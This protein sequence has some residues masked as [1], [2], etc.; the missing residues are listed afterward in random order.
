MV[1]RAVSLNFTSSQE[2][3]IIQ[4]IGVKVT[5]NQMEEKK[6]NFEKPL[7]SARHFTSGASPENGS[8]WKI[9][10]SV[11][12]VRCPPKYKSELKS[13]PVSNPGTVPFE[14]EQIPGRPKDDETSLGSHVAESYK[15]PNLPPGRTLRVG[16]QDFDMA[17]PVVH[18]DQTRSVSQ[19][20]SNIQSLDENVTQSG[21]FRDVKEEVGNSSSGNEDEEFV[22][23]LETLSR[24]ES[25]LINCSLSGLSGL[26]DSGM[27]ECG[28]SPIDSQT[29]D[30][31]MGRFLPAA[32]A[33]A[34]DAPQHASRK[35][36]V[37]RQQ[38]RPPSKIV[39]EDKCPQLRYGPDF[40]LEY[41][42]RNGSEYEE[43]DTDYDE[44]EKFQGKL[45]GLLP[46][47]G[48]RNSLCLLNPLPGMSMRSRTHI[49]PLKK[50]QAGTSSWSCSGTDR[51]ISTVGLETS[52]HQANSKALENY[53]I[54]I[55]HISLDKVGFPSFRE[56]MA[57]ENQSK[58]KNIGSPVAEKTLYVDTEDEVRSLHVRSCSS[59][60]NVQ[61]EF[62]VKEQEI[63][64]EERDQSQNLDSSL[65]NTEALNLM[66][67]GVQSEIRFQIHDF[68]I[69]SS[70]SEAN[71]KTRTGMQ[72]PSGQE[73]DI[74]KGSKMLPKG[75]RKSESKIY[76]ELLAPPPLPKSPS[77][78]W[79]GRTLTSISRK[80]TSVHSY[81]GTWIT[82][83]DQASN[84]KSS[85]PKWETLVRM[86]KMQNKHLGFSEDLLTPIPEA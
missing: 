1:S 3:S 64:D 69:V 25:L 12:S 13:G 49:P 35:Q 8:K 17:F 41:S 53:D 20:S 65:I 19:D 55:H 67:K 40:A 32:K 7:L 84:T 51:K 66:D 36:L 5:N 56:L 70:R 16:R 58:T 85:D 39:N 75:P 47:L 83:K 72:T 71:Q 34:S 68:H 43:S 61:T 29:R 79:L 4:G 50:S 78:S 38:L 74:F 14:W 15:V 44:G 48:F 52:K 80:N 23:A 37:V 54:P 31:M 82:P 57:E 10:D 24:A 22:D 21:S 42:Q 2:A 60:A 11:R 81:G 33:M 86:T 28:M 9:E 77:D 59:D 63:F 26:Q 76:S 62:E 27:N 73:Q 30:F 6:L 18:K 46:G 45:C